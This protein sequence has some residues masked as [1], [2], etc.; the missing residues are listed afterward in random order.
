MAAQRD[1]VLASACFALIA[2]LGCSKQSENEEK[3]VVPAKAISDIAQQGTPAEEAAS[4]AEPATDAAAAQQQVDTTAMS[5]KGGGGPAVSWHL[6][7]PLLPDEVL[8]FKAKGDLDGKTTR[9]KGFEVSEVTRRYG[10]DDSDLRIR[11]TDTSANASLRAPFAKVPTLEEGGQNIA[12]HPAIVEW[13]ATAKSS[14]A[15][16]LVAQRFVVTVRVSKAD[17]DGDAEAI[18]AALKLD[19]LAKL[20][21]AA[22]APA[23]PER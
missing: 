1:S 10:A 17:G 21:A 11:I 7:A 18:A 16:L 15:S 22:P 4:E 3:V 5:A 2:L 19:D 14:S 20:A 9:S 8:D 23:Q 12:R 6:L 13:N